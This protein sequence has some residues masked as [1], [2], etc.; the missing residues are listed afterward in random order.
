MSLNTRSF[1]FYDVKNQ[2]KNTKP[3]K[4]NCVKKCIIGLL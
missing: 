1:K 2:N 4:S 3:K